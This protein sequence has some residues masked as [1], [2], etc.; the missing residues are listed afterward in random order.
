MPERRGWATLQS[1][2]AVVR[3]GG[4][5]THWL[6]G[7]AGGSC[8]LSFTGNHPLSGDAS[9]RGDSTP[10]NHLL[11]FLSPVSACVLIWQIMSLPRLTV[12][13]FVLLYLIVQIFFSLATGEPRPSLELIHRATRRY[14]L[15]GWP[16]FLSF[17]SFW[18]ADSLIRF[19]HLERV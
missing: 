13:R 16:A 11:L 18:F 5:A 2:K 10:M 12:P 7:P 1:R 9:P 6:V 3:P 17:E 4:K 8:V 19:L 14:F 15:R